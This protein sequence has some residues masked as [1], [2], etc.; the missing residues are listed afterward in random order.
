MDVIVG[1][2]TN[3]MEELEQSKEISW[4]DEPCLSSSYTL[5]NT[6]NFND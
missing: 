4:N 1:E 5:N 6:N 3:I 2:L